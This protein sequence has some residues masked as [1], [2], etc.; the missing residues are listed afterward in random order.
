MT[1]ISRERKYRVMLCGTGGDEIN[2]QTIHPRILLADLLTR[3]RPLEL[4]RQLLSWS[5]LI[6][7]PGIQLFSQALIHLFPLSLRSKLSEHGQLEQ[8]INRAF[9]REY[10]VSARQTTVLDGPWF[11]DMRIRNA[12]H[13]LAFLARQM[14]YKSPSVIERRYPYLDQTLVEYLSTVPLDQLIRPGQQRSL[15][16]RALSTILPPEIAMRK[17]KASAG[18]CYSVSLYKHWDYVKELLAY[19]LIANLGYVDNVQLLTALR[20]MRSGQI[21]PHFLRLFKALFLEIWLQGIRER[22]LI[23]FQ[24]PS[25]TLNTALVQSGT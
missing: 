15:M 16:R 5:L 17:T 9:A 21:P 2:G 1:D 11:F 22:G 6:R 7:R 25:A 12:N 20:A 24:S 14:T 3:G 4:Y 10:R 23:V 18:R 13:T 8:W 19:P